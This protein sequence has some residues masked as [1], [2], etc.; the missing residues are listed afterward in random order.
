MANFIFKAVNAKTAPQPV[1]PY[2]YDFLRQF[3][4][5]FVLT[6]EPVAIRDFP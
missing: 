3:R 4:T 2:R 1:G 6:I 5:I